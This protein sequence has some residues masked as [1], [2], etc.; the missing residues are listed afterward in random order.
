M[1]ILTRVTNKPG[2]TDPI[3]IGGAQHLNCFIDKIR[4]NERFKVRDLAPGNRIQVTFCPMASDTGYPVE[5]YRCP[6]GN[7]H[8][9]YFNDALRGARNGEVPSVEG[10]TRRQ[11]EAVIAA[12]NVRGVL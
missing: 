6:S 2:L 7:E 9:A 4:P 10:L 12:I 11:A 1:F 3:G 5:V 8:D